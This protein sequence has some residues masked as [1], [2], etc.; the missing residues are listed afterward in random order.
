[1]RVVYV[2]VVMRHRELG[3]DSN[4]YHDMANTLSRGRGY[5]VRCL[6]ASCELHPTAYFPPLFPL[7]LALPARLGASSLTSLQLSACVI[8]SCTVAAVGFLARRLGGPS[9]G[10]VAA[11]IAAVHPMFFAA[12]GGLM[13][14]S[15]YLLVVTS[16]LLAAYR[17]L[18]Q[19]SVSRWALLGLLIGAAALTRG[20]GLVLLLLA[21]P[22]GA[23][24]RRQPVSRRLALTGVTVVMSLAV[25][26]PWVVRNSLA[27]G[28]P[29][30]LST[31]ADTVVRGA[32]CPA[33]YSG[34]TI[35]YWRFDCL[36]LGANPLE[37]LTLDEV[38]SGHR[39]RRAGIQYASAHK[40]RLVVVSAVRVLRTW[41]VF[42]PFQQARLEAPA[43]RTVGGEQAGWVLYAALIPL[44][45]IGV[46]VLHRGPPRWPLLGVGVVVTLQT[47]LTYGAQR[48]R[49]TAEP[50]I[51]T[52][53]ATTIVAVVR[54]RQTRRG[55][56]RRG[57]RP[58]ARRGRLARVWWRPA[59]R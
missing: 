49:A 34:P 22:V 30:L 14:E 51:V 45:L 48:W 9:V 52:Y 13:S 28:E 27:F 20:E 33:T 44:A 12:D 57:H 6:V 54:S 10:L 29:V 47:L 58:R 46:V 42:D 43:G 21:L 36:S 24:V 19:P 40:G 59:R 15:L 53:A 5:Q 8:G 23:A 4:W 1:V 7:L 32:N 41:G 37:S 2:L 25:V 39:I 50:V 3:F 16:V 11:G 26:L 38:E 56:R 31:N 18:E 35:G 17:A 55:H